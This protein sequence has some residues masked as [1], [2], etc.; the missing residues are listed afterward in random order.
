MVEGGRPALQRTTVN[1][2]PVLVI[3]FP[4]PSDTGSYFEVFSLADVRTILSTLLRV[5]ILAGTVATVAGVVLGGW[6]AGRVLRPLREVTE[7]ASRIAE[8]ELGTRLDEQLDRDLTVLS[9][10]FNRMADTLQARI[11]REARFASD[12]A[13]ELRTPITS[14]VTS[15][16]VIEGR[17]PELSEQG[18]EALEILT[19][20]V[21]R[22]QHTVSDLT[23]IAKHDAGVVTADLELHPIPAVIGGILKRLHRHDI[24]T[25]F[26]QGALTA[27]VRADERRLERIIANLIENADTHGGGVTRLAV[28][29]G[30]KAVTIAVEDEGPGVPESERTRIFERFSRGSSTY[31]SARVTGSGLGLSLAAENTAL[32]GGRIWVEERTGGGARFVVELEAETV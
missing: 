30:R 22:L 1:G 12:V 24:A 4:L 28:R 6:M 10:A 25:D 9:G 19:D 2:V 31:R 3:G 16:A 18:R 21:K 32:Q 5:L 14:L 15:L 23:E 26:D 13:H 17:R 27:L 20:D 7:V 11:A 29:S 8:G